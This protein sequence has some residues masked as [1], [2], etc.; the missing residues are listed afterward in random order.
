MR[1]KCPDGH[2]R[3]DQDNAVI[4]ESSNVAASA[5]I[6]AGVEIAALKA[7]FDWPYKRALLSCPEDLYGGTGTVKRGLR[8]PA[9]RRVT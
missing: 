2:E 3:G 1:Q 8:A 9:R 5:F 7:G 4:G 6:K